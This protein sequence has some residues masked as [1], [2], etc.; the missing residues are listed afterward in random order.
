[1]NQILINQKS[2]KRIR[3]M[4]KVFFITTIVLL[5]I[6]I[7]VF[8]NSYNY[9]ENLEEISL[10]INKNIRLSSIYLEENNLKIYLGK[11]KI[12]KIDLEYIIFND[13]SE[14]LMKI[15]PCKFYGKNLEEK[16]N[17]AIAG[18]NYNDSRFF[19]RLSE[20][21]IKDKIKMYSLD[22]K[23]Y[24]YTIYDIF[25]TNNDDLSVLKNN[26]NYELT[27]VTCNNF[28]NKRLIIKS[29]RT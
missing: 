7:L 9:E 10:E 1:M 19:G 14:E 5:I 17:I 8:I 25:E 12:E 3:Y 18:H 29:Y 27:L 28:N 15:S 26:N 22:N 20:L 21:E 4:Y 6:F 24:I 11:I 23:E 13:F 16:G 2:N